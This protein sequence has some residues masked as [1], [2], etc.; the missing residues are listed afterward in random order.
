MKLAL[1]NIT[2]SKVKCAHNK[3][4]YDWLS[5]EIPVPF[6]N[7]SKVRIRL[8]FNDQ[9]LQDYQ[10]AIKQTLKNTLFLGAQDREKAKE[11]IFAYY[12]DFVLD[13]GEECLEDMPPQEDEENIFN[14]IHISSLSICQSSV[15]EDF[16]SEFSGGCD[17]EIE[18]GISFSYK[19]GKLL[20][21]VSSYDHVSNSDAYANKSIDKFIYYGNNI[22]TNA[23]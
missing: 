18:H 9:E 21:K 23:R 3:D 15:T 20:A 7:N 17:W 16:Y 4:W 13:A 1:G 8:D 14:F 22:K 5:S 2:F 19:D 12:K 11:H 10:K 6:L